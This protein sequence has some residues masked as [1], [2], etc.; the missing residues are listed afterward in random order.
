V[1]VVKFLEEPRRGDI[2][3]LHVNRTTM[4]PAIV[5]ALG[6]GAGVVNGRL[7]DISKRLISRNLV[8]AA[9]P[10]DGPVIIKYNA[11][12]GG[13]PDQRKAAGGTRTPR[14]RR[15]LGRL[16]RRLP[17]RWTRRLDGRYV[18]CGG[19]SLV[20]RWVWNDPALV[21]ERFRPEQMDGLYVLRVAVLL[22]GSVYQRH[23][24]STDPVVK[25][26]RARRKAYSEEPLPDVV[27][28]RLRELHVDYAK[29]DWVMNGGEPVILDVNP[30]PMRT[31]PPAGAELPRFEHLARGIEALGAAVR[32]TRS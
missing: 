32:E 16:R 17:W 27:L 28:A 25:A 2:G 20:P 12:A 21:V 15:T 31:A 5:G 30:T 29:V 6:G 13:A 1:R 23:H 9:G 22:G 8:T 26:R 4:T 19:R 18:V 14:W 7:L 10:D 3:F 24:F 11:N